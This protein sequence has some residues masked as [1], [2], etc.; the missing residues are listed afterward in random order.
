MY[1]LYENVS[2]NQK[3]NYCQK[4]SCLNMLCICTLAC[5]GVTTRGKRSLKNIR[6]RNVVNQSK[7]HTRWNCTSTCSS[8]VTR[9]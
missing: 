6:K 4:R 3:K 7:K 9:A 2:S 1:D 8:V 5:L